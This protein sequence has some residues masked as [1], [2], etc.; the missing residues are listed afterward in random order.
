MPKIK[1]QN[2]TSV[3]PKK[4]ALEP[5]STPNISAEVQSKPIAEIRPK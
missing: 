3:V 5:G 4:V 2:W 1:N